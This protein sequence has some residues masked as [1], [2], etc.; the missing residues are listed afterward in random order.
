VRNHDVLG[1]TGYSSA[2]FLGRLYAM[3]TYETTSRTEVMSAI[4]PQET[5]AKIN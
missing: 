1:E 4:G 3:R 2:M 5:P